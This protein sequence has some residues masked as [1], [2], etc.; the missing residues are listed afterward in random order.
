MTEIPPRAI[1]A[2]ALAVLVLCGMAYFKSSSTSRVRC[3]DTATAK[4]ALD[5][6]ASKLDDAVRAAKNGDITT[7]AADMRDAAASLRTAATASSA[8]P[9]VSKPLVVAA[10]GYDRVAT[11]YANR[12]ESTATL[13]ASTAIAFVNTSTAALRRTSVPRCR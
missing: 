7:A 8:D 10:D 6:A 1:Y 12:D 5:D 9:A 13:Y 4:P 3:I 2:I 11:A